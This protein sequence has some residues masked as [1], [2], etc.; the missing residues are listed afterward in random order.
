MSQPLDWSTYDETNGTTYEQRYFTGTAYSPRLTP[1]LAFLCVGGEGPGFTAT[2]LSTSAHCTGDMV[3]LARRYAR[4]GVEVVM[5]ALEHRYY[6]LSLPAGDPVAEGYL[7]HLSSDYALRDA[8]AF[9]GRMNEVYPTIKSWTTFGGSYP[10]MLSSWV[11]LR[12]PGLVGQSVSSSSPVQKKL[13]MS[14]YNDKVGSVLSM[15]AVGGS[16][17]CRR[18]VADGHAAAARLLESEAGRRS[19]AAMFDVCEVDGLDDPLGPV[20]NREMLAG[21]GLIYVPAQSND[22]ACEGDL[23]DVEGLC[24]ALLEGGE[25][26]EPL[27]SLARVAKVQNGGEC[28][29]VDW[30]G[31]IDMLKSLAAVAGGTRSWLY[32]TCN[33]FGFYQTC[34]EGSGCPYSQGYHPLDQDL[35]MCASVFNITNVQERVAGTNVYG[36]WNPEGTRVLYVNGDVDPWSTL[37]VTKGNPAVDDNVDF[38]CTP[39]FWVEGASHHFWTHEVLETDGEEVDEARTKIWSQVEEWI[40]NPD[41]CSD[42]SS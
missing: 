20:R 4:A 31:Q 42:P 1:S 41:M 34:E 10:G 17:A 14:S 21:D 35:E 30:E 6:G 18:V 19:L 16:R 28:K 3:E 36:G 5:F 26:E 24:T 8:E 40:S 39:A 37:A 2:V 38:E 15:P 9:I 25:G 13:D 11:R 22:P 23:C 7:D 27:E 29:L 33:E 32:Q 12:Y